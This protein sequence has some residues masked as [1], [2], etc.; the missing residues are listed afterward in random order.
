MG[1]PQQGQRLRVYLVVP[2]LIVGLCLGLIRVPAIQQLG[3]YDTLFNWT[4]LELWTGAVATAASWLLGL[5]V[6]AL[7]WAWQRLKYRLAQAP[8]RDRA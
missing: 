4:I 7:R 8:P 6:I 1:R 3:E 5:A 2:P